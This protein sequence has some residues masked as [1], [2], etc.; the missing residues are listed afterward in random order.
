[1]NS[2]SPGLT[3]EN[4]VML[5]CWFMAVSVDLLWREFGHRQRCA[6]DLPIGAAGYARN[7]PIALD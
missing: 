1:L 4:W 6:V 2:V 5:T 7:A 3:C